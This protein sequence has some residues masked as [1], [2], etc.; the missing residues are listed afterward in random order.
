M[1]AVVLVGALAYLGA[2]GAAQSAL[3]QQT[4]QQLFA[5]GNWSG[6]VH[7]MDPL[8]ARNADQDYY[9]GMAL[10]HLGRWHAA[11]EALEAGRRLAPGDVRFPVELAGVAFNGKEYPLAA[12]RLR[13]ALRIDPKDEYA[14][15]FL[16]TVFFLEGNLI[17]ALKYWNRVGKPEIDAVQ[18]E[19][20]PKV[21]PVLLDRAF[22]FSPASTLLLPEFLSTK[23]RIRGLGVFPEYQLELD[24]LPNGHFNADF[25]NDEMDGL[26]SGKLEALFRVLR[27]VGFQEID[28]DYSNFH[29]KAI[30]FDSIFRWDAQKRRIFV[31]VSG[32]LEGGAKY[33]WNLAADLRDENWAIRSSFTGAAP[34]LAGFN[35]RTGTVGFSLASYASERWSWSAGGRVSHRGFRN[36]SAGAVLTPQM[37]SNGYEL[38]QT[39]R[40]DAT[41]WRVPER[42][43]EANTALGS[44]AARLWSDPQR[45]FEKLTGEVAWHWFPRAAGDDYETRESFR[46]GRTLG[47]PPF[48]ELF[49]LGLERDNDL[50][51]IAHIGTRDGRKGSAPLGRDYFLEHWETNKNIIG[52]GPVGVRLAP[53][54]DIGKIT[55]PGTG[56]GSHQWLFDAGAEAK[57]RVFSTGLVFSYGRDLRS[58]NN[59][60]YVTL[61]K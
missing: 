15:N 10:A 1:R 39:A 53:V 2:G 12:R 30:N 17:A 57:L 3:S 21:S 24:A 33:R 11:R 36:V 14:N 50:P 5:A 32:P 35:M 20:V 55:D 8:K 28:P 51:M 7:R 6:I 29:H 27:G 41:V 19:P 22:E 56:L 46:A 16:G 43:F 34:V 52:L 47:Q 58:R 31:H 59:A 37:L 25:R 42:R 48:D 45:G 23:A 26:G 60:F 44:E 38:K 4:L 9:Y 54:V 40:F 61:L 13:Q 49:I 18:Y